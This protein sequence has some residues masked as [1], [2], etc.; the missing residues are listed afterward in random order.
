MGGAKKT[1]QM[2]LMKELKAFKADPP[3]YV[4]LAHVDEKNIHDWHFLMQGPHATPYEGGWYVARLKFPDAYPVQPPDVSVLTPSGRFEPGVK[5]CTALSSF[6]P[7]TGPPA[8]TTSTIVKGLLSFMV[9][10][11]LTTG[12]VRST[13]EEARAARASVE[14]NRGRPG[15]KRMFPQLDGDL[16]ALATAPPPPPPPPTTTPTR[17]RREAKRR[18]I[19]DAPRKGVTRAE[20]DRKGR[21]D[22]ERREGRRA[23]RRT[24]GREAA[25]T[26]PTY[27]YVR[28]TVQKIVIFILK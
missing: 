15:L 21:K 6:H 8:W 3:P 17:T 12:S 11:E 18:P 9:E 23:L 5:L 20:R 13:E 7:E 16:A 19:D 26:T 22:R 4:P 28:R 14:W 24:L 10:D 1:G 25:A 2:R 27:R